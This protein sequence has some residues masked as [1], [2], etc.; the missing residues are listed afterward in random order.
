MTERSDSFAGSWGVLT[1]YLVDADMSADDWNRRVDSFNVS[2]LVDQLASIGARHYFITVGQN[3]GHYCAPNACYDQFVDIHPSKC[4]K[5]DLVADL[6]EPLQRA[7]IALM[8]YLP[9]NAPEH[10]PVAAGHLEWEKGT[11]EPWTRPPE[12]VRSKPLLSF[13]RKWEAIVSEWSVRWQSKVKGWWIDGCYYDRDMYRNAD[14]PNFHSLAA[15]LRAG[16]P[17]AIVAFNN[18]KSDAQIHSDE[19][20]YTAGEVSHWFPVCY[21]RWV[22]QGSHRAQFHVL[23]FLGSTWGNGDLRFPDEFVVGYTRL[24]TR[25]GG[26][27]TWDVPISGDGALP[28]QCLAQLG[29]IGRQRSEAGSE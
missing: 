15:A 7:G 26:A 6:Y 11:P 12:E 19:D 20:D 5:R 23:S 1:H 29:R 17:N 18:G 3:S 4:S 24:V 2:R 9:S 27:V 25:N 10:D 21:R 16:N 13:Q 8:V 22:T 14:P 28:R